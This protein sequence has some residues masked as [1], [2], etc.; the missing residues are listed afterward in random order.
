MQNADNY[1]VMEMGALTA[2]TVFQFTGG[3]HNYIFAQ[4]HMEDDHP[5]T[6]MVCIET[7]EVI[8]YIE[9]E[10][11]LMKVLVPPAYK[12]QHF[13]MN[14]DIIA[15]DE[16]QMDI[17]ME[18]LSQEIARSIE[19]LDLMLC[20][21]ESGLDEDDP[22]YYEHLKKITEDRYKLLTMATTIRPRLNE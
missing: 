4:E 6:K 19:K 7:G 8:A 17:I 16:I 2:G 3:E 18:G 15:N 22:N 13:D 14:G 5:D 12:I 20:D 1:Q 9:E 10:H 11:R 21:E